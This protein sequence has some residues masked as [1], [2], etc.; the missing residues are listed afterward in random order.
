MAEFSFTV[1]KRDGRSRLGR[2]A[3]GHGSFETPAFM[4][5]GD[6]GVHQGGDA[7]AGAGVRVR[8]GPGEHVSFDAQAGGP[9]GGRAWGIAEVFGVEWADV[10]GFRGVPGFFAVG[11]AGV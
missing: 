11:L 5:V 1:E 2:V 4:A 3:M 10:D 6:A 9:D 7:G 8:G